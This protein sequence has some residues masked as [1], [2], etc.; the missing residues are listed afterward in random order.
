MDAPTTVIAVVFWLLAG[1]ALFLYGI[2]MMSRAMRKA[3]GPTLRRAFEFVTRTRFHG[4]LVGTLLTG[5]IQSSSA[6]TVMVVGF[7]N[8]GLLK[9]SQSIGLILGANI[10][11][12]I[13]PH[14]TA[15]NLDALAMPLLGG[16]FLVSF[17]SRRR[18]VRHMGRA[19]MGFGLLFFGL[20]L[21][22]LAVIEFRDEIQGWLALFTE[23]E[24]LGQVSAF[25]L[26]AAATAII[27]SS[28]ATI[29]MLQVI[30]MGSSSVGLSLFIPLIVGAQ[31]GT[32][33]TAML[34]SL[35][36]SL[37]AKRAAVA[38]LMFNLIGALLTWVLYRVYLWAIPLTSLELGRQIA[39]CHLMIRLVN[40]VIFLPFTGAF[41]RLVTRLTPGEDKLSAAP[42]YLD[43]QQ[44]NQPE[45]ALKSA[46]LEIIRMYNTCLEMLQD[47]VRAFIDR[48]AAAGE[49][50]IKQE[51]LIDDLYK[52]TGE[53]L[54]MV[55]RAEMPFELA[56]RPALW[57][58]LMSDVERI[59]DHAENIIELSG[60]GCGGSILFSRE[61]IGEMEETLGL[62]MQM[63]AT[64]HQAM[65]DEGQELMLSV[66][67][68]KERVNTT[69][70]LIL[71]R[72]AERL[73]KGALT[74]TG[75]ILFVEVIMNLRRVANHL[76]NI[77]ASVTSNR[78]EHTAQIRKLK[79]E[80]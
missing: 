73:E 8:A 37:S 10:G 6:S 80:M 40:V 20:M 9:F 15:F 14:I 49:L 65:Q 69:V 45:R 41:A 53:Y 12:T 46:T 64:V 44:V 42:E 31:V 52:T 2:E 17:L 57:M 36:S 21:M 27:Q 71:D 25:L 1:L 16:G 56:T 30:A 78:P 66:L 76:R 23:K 47:S 7:I 24:L 75:G 28:A 39:N 43:F 11:A 72:H 70:D 62:I 33:I 74:P 3:A 26:A 58:H 67:Q 32:C 35:Q 55:S 19:V 18:A 22:K 5:V 13:T 77:A 4:L 54:L 29:A 79:E 38:H 48:D 51:A 63:G 60:V 61:E 50:V 34:A 59:G 68:W